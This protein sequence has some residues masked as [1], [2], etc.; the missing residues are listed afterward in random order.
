MT[1]SGAAAAP[2]IPG[3][4]YVRPIGHGGFSDVYLYEQSMPRRGVAI[5]VLRTDDLSPDT[6]AQFAAEANLM[7]RVSNHSNI[8]DIYT[9]DLDDAGEPYLIMEYCSGGSLGSTYRYYP[10][11]VID[12]IALGIKLSGALEAAHRAGIVH[13]DIKPANILLTEYGVPV[14][15]D[16]GISVITEDLP[17]ATRRMT[18]TSDSEESSIGMSIPWAAPEALWDSPVSDTSSDTYS[19]AATLYSLLEGRAPQEVPGGS[20]SSA[21]IAA[22]LQRGFIAAMKRPDIPPALQSVLWR[23]L[24]HD[25]DARFDSAASLGRALQQVQRDLG[26]EVTS[27]EVPL[28]AQ[29]GARHES[30]HPALQPTPHEPS[31]GQARVLHNSAAP[32]ASA[33]AYSPVPYS[34][35]PSTDS[36]SP[37][38]HRGGMSAPPN[39]SPAPSDGSATDSPRWSRRR[40]TL[41]GL[42]AFVVVA[43]MAVLVLWPALGLGEPTYAGREIDNLTVEPGPSGVYAVIIPEGLQIPGE[44]QSRLVKTGDGEA[45]R[46]QQSTIQVSLDTA[47]W[48]IEGVNLNPLESAN[49]GDAVGL[50]VEDFTDALK[51]DAGTLRVGDIILV[52]APLGTFANLH[53]DF[54]ITDSDAALVV[55]QIMDIY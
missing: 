37:E 42:A 34:S 15:T 31:D 8:A 40:L 21:H 46:D 33:V 10:M 22:R 14:L 54:D 51:V 11:S 55:L 9:A 52:A 48:D 13:R 35:T 41:A 32:A 27:L 26:L 36:D 25:R 4:R 43:A 6:R 49:Q 12:V 38:A 7:A 39:E 30:L 19:L 3:Y 17:E 44:L 2:Y 47:T 5:K 29:V 18:I 50:S 28:S 1:E 16:F 53:P 23:G 20:N 45:R 24:A